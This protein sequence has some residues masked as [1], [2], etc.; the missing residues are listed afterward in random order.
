LEVVLAL[1]L[2]AVA[3]AV[4]G[5]A[6]R[7][8]ISATTA[9]RDDVSRAQLAR[10]VLRRI[11]D[12]LRCAVWYAAPDAASLLGSSAEALAGSDS[13]AA[14]EEEALSDASGLDDST[15]VTDSMAVPSLPGI[16]GDA[17]QLEVDVSRLPGA[18]GDAW[19]ELAAADVFLAPI[20]DLRTVA[21]FISPGTGDFAPGLVRAEL[22]HAVSLWGAANGGLSVT[23][24][25]LEPWVPEIVGLAFA[26]YDGSQ[27]VTS[28]DSTAQGGLPIA[29]E[30]SIALAGTGGPS[31]SNPGDSFAADS[32]EA[33]WY[34][35]VVHLP[36]SAAASPAQDSATATETTQTDDLS[37]TEAAP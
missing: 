31:E 21:Y 25:D 33:A 27:W 18:V 24:L 35:L 2:A 9:G 20:A 17:E 22:D 12:D 16:Y 4:V 6:I 30:V 3:L 5:V 34:S 10:A 32:A 8:T 23:N 14:S 28:W 36:M 29:V 19:S 11:A 26:Y 1:S 13:G 7:G 37:T 15:S